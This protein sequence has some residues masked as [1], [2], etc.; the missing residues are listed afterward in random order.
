MSLTESIV[1]DAALTWLRELGYAICHG[2]DI[3]PGEPAAER[4]SFGDVVL[5]GR[6]RDA[7][8][9]LNPSI[10]DDAQGQSGTAQ[11]QVTLSPSGSVEAAAI[12]QS[13]G[14]FSLDREALSAARMTRY[15][16]EVR[17]CAPVG[18]NYLFTVTFQS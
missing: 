2:P 10:P 18:G 1:E 12:Y 9:R 3:A 4:D 15:L 13:T 11:V 5:V 8:H 6:L 7:I 14:V 16:P 17:D